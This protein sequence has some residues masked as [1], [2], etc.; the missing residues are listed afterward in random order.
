[1]SVT[2]DMYA[3]VAVALLFFYVGAFIKKYV[4]VLNKFCIP[5]PVVGGICFSILNLILHQTG[6]LDL[7]MDSVFQ[8]LCMVAF[9]TSIGY[10]ASLRVIAK[11][12]KQV[13]ILTVITGVLICMQNVIG[14]Y[15][16]QFFGLGKLLGL[17]LGSVSMVGGHGNAGSFGPQLEEMGVVGAATVG[18]A[19][20]T[21]GLV[22][23]NLTGGP[24]AD[25]LIRKN[26]LKTSGVGLSKDE[27]VLE[28]EGTNDKIQVTEK[29]FIAHTTLVIFQIFVCMALGVVINA[30]VK[31]VT[32]ITIPVFLCSMLVAV[33]IRNVSEYTNIYPVYDQEA[34]ILGSV[35]LNIFLALAL[36]S[37]KLWQ[38]IDLAVPMI[39]ILLVQTGVTMLF[40]SLV[41]F[42]LMG[43]NYEAA[44]MAAAQMGYGLGATPN[45]MAN[46]AAVEEKYGAAPE[47]RV[48]IP[49]VG[50]L[51][52]SIINAALI[53]VFINMFS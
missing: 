18:M 40:V 17:T 52:T 5:T 34:N 12:G 41:T 8:N 7:S 30:A 50:G 53:T 25:F 29:G 32:G 45:A 2:L 24:V 35:S 33:V 47:A 23:G 1:M 21:F 15:L 3:T 38:L 20:A 44:V 19:A 9:F 46:I 42:P 22:F 39:V 26:K 6:I 36:M 16:G 37:V 11:A 31:N 4:N 43:K 10:T 48:V 27:V 49:F 13:V 14:G 28:G 51:F